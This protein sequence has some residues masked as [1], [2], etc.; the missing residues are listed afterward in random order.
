M[1]KN[2]PFKL[3]GKVMRSLFC[4]KLPSGVYKEIEYKIAQTRE[5]YEQAFELVQGSYLE[6]KLTDDKEKIYRLSKFNI[7]PTT[8]VFIA[9]FR[10]EVIAT[11][12]QI[13]DT[14]LG[15]PIEEFCDISSLRNK[16][17]RVCE[18]S[19]LAVRKDWRSRSEG[20]FFPL[21]TYATLYCKQNIGI[22]YIAIVTR[23]SVKDF[24]QQILNFKA[25]EN[26]VKKHVKYKYPSLA[27]YLDVNELFHNMNLLYKNQPFEKNLYL[28][29]KKFP[30]KKQCYFPEKKY[31]IS[32]D[33]T[34]T[35]NDLD[36][37]FNKKVELFSSLT[38]EDIEIVKSIYYFD[39]YKQVIS[40][41]ELKYAKNRRYPRFVVHMTIYFKHLDTM[42]L[43]KVSKVSEGGF[44][45][46]FQDEADNIE[47]LKGAILLSKK[48]DCIFEAK[49]V[50][51]QGKRAGYEFE[52]IDENTWLEFITYSERLMSGAIDI[53]KNDHEK[54]A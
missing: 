43:A 49:Q 1:I 18:F 53:E 11:I 2:L 9:K 4:V 41:W 38:K 7:L 28:I 54:V 21:V 46:V 14:S 3:K 23:A 25:I 5:E 13:T 31:M 51:T 35:A 19:S 39:N 32:T 48:I 30:W 12:S 34:F 45:I 44:E 33:Q 29:L 20:V 22:D 36:Y 40:P 52:F 24:Y 6:T 15:L 16:G 26:K 8:T 10:G 17:S 50:W 37:F 27:Q 42:K 47:L